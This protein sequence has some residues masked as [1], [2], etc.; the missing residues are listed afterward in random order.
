MPKSDLSNDTLDEFIRD[1]TGYWHMKNPKPCG[2]CE[3][4]TKLQQLIAEE[5][6]RELEML[7]A[8]DISFDRYPMVIRQRIK[9]L[10]NNQ[11][12]ER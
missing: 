4:K 8:L 1:L 3:A 9:E 2:H 10:E 12:R 11:A 6:I 5:K 7:H